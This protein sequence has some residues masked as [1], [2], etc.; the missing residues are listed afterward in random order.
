[1]QRQSSP[2]RQRRSGAVV[3]EM[4][5][6]LPIFMMVVWG[7]VEFGRAMMV[8]QLVTNAARYGAREAIL[9]GSTNAVVTAS[10]QQFLV[11]TVKGIKGSDVTVKVLVTPGTGNPDPKNDL[12]TSRLK[13][14]CNVTV[15]IPYSKVAY[16]SAT[17]LKTAS[18]RGSCSMRHE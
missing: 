11:D 13:D 3:V 7:I 18:L 17:F 10:V 5:I 9:D 12:A 16:F 1:M 2:N 8:G 6:V 15:T 4:A 14:I